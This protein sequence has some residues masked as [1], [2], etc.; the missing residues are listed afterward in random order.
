M[1]LSIIA[2]RSSPHQNEHALAMMSGLECHSIQ[3][4][5]VN[6]PSEADDQIVVC[7]GWRMGQTMADQGH[8]VLV[9]ERGYLGDRF[10]WT[11]LG[12]D[13][14][15]GRAKMPTI[16][17]PS[18]F[19]E[20]FS[21]LLKDSDSTSEYVLLIGQVPRDAALA[22]R[23][24]S[25]WYLDTAEECERLYGLPTVFRPH[26]RA[27]S[28]SYPGGLSSASEDLAVQLGRAAAVVTFNSNT[29]VESVLAGVPTIAMDR[30]SMAWNVTAHDLGK[31]YEGDRLE[32]AY[33]M[34]WKQWR[35]KE[36]EDGTAIAH[37]LE[38][39]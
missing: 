25:N 37:L 29:G 39:M 19:N 23:D 11:S 13:G 33:Q 10:S 6:S 31:T 8:R 20:H 26:P 1:R 22:G 30:G 24:L 36:I 3:S 2:S 14:L 15:N 17:D 38:I 16:N 27:P 7:W 4:K 9:M 18:R 12:W 21:G 35:M 5:I 28:G 32:W 34:A